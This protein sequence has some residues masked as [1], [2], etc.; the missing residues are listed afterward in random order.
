VGQHIEFT[1]TAADAEDGDLAATSLDWTSRL[2]HCP[3][4]VGACHAHPM[5]AFPS[6]DSGTLIA[7]EH[8]YPA[9]LE[10]R[11]TATDSRGLSASR[12]I[13]LYPRTVDL[14]IASD[15][16]GVVLNAGLLTQAAPFTMT[17]IEDS[18][19]T[20]SAPLQ[21]KIGSSLYRWVDWSDGGDIAHT[22]LAEASGEYVA[23]FRSLDIGPLPPPPPVGGGGGDSSQP[24]PSGGAPKPR[25]KCRKG[26]K[27]KKVRGKQRCLKKK[28]HRKRRGKKGRGKR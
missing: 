7:P 12:A 26:F 28:K 21:Q 25:H 18:H 20:L 16:A 1:G 6:A 14:T 10:L 8:D 17:V 5:Q 22:I 11:L 4:G 15:P 24:P 9:H 2:Y 13:Q 27:K 3:G 19:L 23:S